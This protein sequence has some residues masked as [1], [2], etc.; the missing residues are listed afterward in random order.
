MVGTEEELVQVDGALFLL[1]ENTKEAEC[2]KETISLIQWLA[3]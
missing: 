2:C 1:A 3:E